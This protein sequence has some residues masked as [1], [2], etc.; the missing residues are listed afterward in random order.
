M[1]PQLPVPSSIYTFVSAV[2]FLYV[3]TLEMPW[4]KNCFP[5]Q[6]WALY[7]GTGD[8]VAVFCISPV[9]VLSSFS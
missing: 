4:G 1:V 9:L 5:R 6:N 7:G 8:P 3:E 2:Q